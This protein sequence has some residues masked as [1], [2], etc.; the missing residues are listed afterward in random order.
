M[1]QKSD[2][3]IISSFVYTHDKVGNR[4]S[5]SLADGDVVN[6]GYDASYQLISEIRKDKKKQAGSKKK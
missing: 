4:T 5:M 1:I 2:G 3:T 6:Y